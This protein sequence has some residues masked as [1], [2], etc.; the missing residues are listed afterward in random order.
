[1]GILS[2]AMGVNVVS[3]K[4]GDGKTFPKAGDKL[5]MHYTGTLTDGTKFDS[6][7]DRGKPFSFTIGVGQA[8]REITPDFG[9]G[10]RGAGGVIPPN[11]DLIFDV[12]LLRI[13]PPGGGFMG[14]LSDV[15]EKWPLLVL[16]GAAIYWAIRQFQT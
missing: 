16:W 5:E 9:Y 15:L 2:A 12:E 8:I 11:A 10:A 1:M 6:S 3:V 4:E 13:L 14:W 7:R